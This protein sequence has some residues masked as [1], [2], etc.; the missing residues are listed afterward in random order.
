MPLDESKPVAKEQPQRN[1]DD[2]DDVVALGSYSIAG[3][4]G[5]G[6][7]SSSSAIPTNRAPRVLLRVCLQ[8]QSSMMVLKLE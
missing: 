8:M 2:D 7:K 5:S 6:S 1:H 3:S 4:S